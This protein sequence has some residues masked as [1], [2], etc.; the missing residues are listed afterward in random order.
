MQFTIKKSQFLNALN[1]ASHGIGSK[2]SIPALM[3]FKIEVKDN[4]ICITS[5]NGTI[6]ILTKVP[7]TM[8]DQTYVRDAVPGAILL[9]ARILLDM[10]RKLEGEE[11]SITIVDEVNA[12]I[13]DG[14]SL[15]NLN[16]IDAEEYPD[17]IL[18]EGMNPLTIKAID[19]I[20]LTEQTAFAADKNFDKILQA[21]NLKVENQK[22]IATATNTAI[23]SRKTLSLDED[24]VGFS[25][26]VP[27]NTLLE[28]CKLLEGVSE[29]RFSALQRKCIFV[30]GNT[31][32]SSSLVDGPY[33]NLP[34]RLFTQQHK[35]VLEVSASQILSTIDRVSLLAS[36]HDSRIK[37]SMNPDRVKISC[38]SEQIGSCSEDL[39]AFQLNGDPLD[40]F[41][42][43][44]YLTQAIKAVGSEDVQICFND[45]NTPFTIKNPR[46]DSIIEVLTPLRT[47]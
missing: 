32:L 43:A 4:N 26:N 29:V 11:V 44:I 25:V 45:F 39:P 24:V 8:N 35:T 41:I 37:L 17:I 21:I 19:L 22:L 33:P 13:E 46:D 34:S 5:S 40:I 36:D 18:D 9:N 27:A 38:V 15:Y 47:R 14:K 12:K 7:F 10:V 31:L 28:V 20:R 1:I 2:V 23:M 3:C 42:N 6:T 16:C 30:F